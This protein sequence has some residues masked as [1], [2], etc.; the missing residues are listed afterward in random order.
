MKLLYLSESPEVPLALFLVLAM[1]PSLSSIQPTCRQLQMVH[2]E[3]IPDNSAWTFIQDQNSLPKWRFYARV[4]F[5]V[6][7]L[8]LKYKQPNL[9]FLRGRLTVLALSCNPSVE[10]SF[11]SGYVIAITLWAPDVV[12]LVRSLMLSS[13]DGQQSVSIHTHKMIVFSRCSCAAASSCAV[14]HHWTRR[15]PVFT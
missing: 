14:S 15:A 9:V 11:F 13:A 2:S 8:Y 12:N 4:S 3:S 10:R 1:Y 5:R 6:A 7:F